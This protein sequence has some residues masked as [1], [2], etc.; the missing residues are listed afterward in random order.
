VK[1]CVV[2]SRN[3]QQS[4]P[5]KGGGNQPLISPFG[6]GQWEEKQEVGDEKSKPGRE[7][8]GGRLGL[9]FGALNTLPPRGNNRI[10]RR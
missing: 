6:K 4:Y 7:N 9:R 5:G 8:G 2:K 1:K 10:R 3:Y